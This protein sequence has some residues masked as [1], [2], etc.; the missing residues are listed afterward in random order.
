MSTVSRCTPNTREASRMLILSTMQARR[1]RAYIST[2][3]I[4]RTFHRL[5]LS[6]TEGGGRYDFPPP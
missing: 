2:A 5:I 3:N 4:H 6:L 1:T